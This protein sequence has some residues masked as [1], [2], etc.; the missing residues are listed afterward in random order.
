MEETKMDY[1]FHR[2]DTQGFYKLDIPEK[3]NM[4]RLIVDYWAE[5]FGRW[6]RGCRG[7]RYMG[8]RKIEH[9]LQILSRQADFHK[10][11]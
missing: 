6:R 1:T 3:L 7:T 4:A 10:G 5:Y 2:M 8:V 9:Y 11:I